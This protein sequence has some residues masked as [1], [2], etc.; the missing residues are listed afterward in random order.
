MRYEHADYKDTDD[1]G[2]V[3]LGTEHANSKVA[4]AWADVGDPEPEELYS[5]T[6]AE[7]EKLGELYDWAVENGY[8]PLDFDTERGRIYME[9]AEWVDTDVEG[10]D[11]E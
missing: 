11:D 9:D 7:R 1:R 5:P 2:R 4:I 10:L 8:K 3:T 6:E